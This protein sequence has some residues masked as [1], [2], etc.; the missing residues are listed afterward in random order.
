M[1]LIGIGEELEDLRPFDADDFAQ[2]A[3]RA[4]AAARGGYGSAMRMDAWVIWLV[5]AVIL[6]AGEIATPSFFLAPFAVGAPARRRSSRCLGGAGVLGVDHLRASLTGADVRVRAA[7]SPAATCT[8]PAAAA[9][10]HGG[11][12]RAQRDRARARSPTTR[13]ADA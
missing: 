10:R 9:H 2:R 7:R 3:A 1:K 13:A 5:A 4:D 11:A 6:A 8:G 12:D